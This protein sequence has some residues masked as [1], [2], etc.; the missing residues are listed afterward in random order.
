MN[1]KKIKRTQLYRLQAL[2]REAFDR[3]LNMEISTR[4]TNSDKP[5]LVGFITVE[6]MHDDYPYL[7]FS[8]YESM[9]FWTEE[10]S[11]SAWDEEF[12]KITAFIRNNS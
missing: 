12:D 7:H 2:Q 1:D 5:W 6:G 11:K 9:N 3:G 10:E 4:A 8:F